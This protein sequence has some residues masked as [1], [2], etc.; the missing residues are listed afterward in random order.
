MK[1][2]SRS[3]STLA[4][5]R[6]TQSLLVVFTLVSSSKSQEALLFSNRNRG[7]VELLFDVMFRQLRN[8]L[9]RTRERTDER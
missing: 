1:Y 6:P 2:C 3:T 7:Q 4:L 9:L 8:A 5:Q